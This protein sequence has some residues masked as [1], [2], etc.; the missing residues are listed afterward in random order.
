MDAFEQSVSEILWMEGYWVRTSIKV[1]LTKEEK[2]LIGRP[3]SPRWELDIVAY[4]GRDNLLKI[5]ECKS[6]LD[7]RGVALRAF[8]GSDEKSAERF[9]LFADGKLRAVVFERLRL[10]FAE[11]GACRPN[12]KLCLACGRIASDADRTGL[13]RHF[14]EKNWELWDEPW[15]RERLK[16]MSDQGYENQVSA[17]VAK[18][19]LRGR[20][21]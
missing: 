16:R 6:Y 18:L 14:A 4:S 5:V 2:R 3:S 9:K 11:S 20:V 15:L 19:L 17:V 8:D 21:E 13:Q 7:S 1:E 12:A 10:Q